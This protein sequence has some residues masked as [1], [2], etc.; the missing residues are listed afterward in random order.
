MPFPFERKVVRVPFLYSSFEDVAVVSEDVAP[1]KGADLE[2]QNC[3]F[4]VPKNT[5]GNRLSSN[6]TIFEDVVVVLR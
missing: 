2:K 1:E 3:S 6:D 4:G 5:W